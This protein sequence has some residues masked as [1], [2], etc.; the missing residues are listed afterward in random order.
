MKCFEKKKKKTFFIP[1]EMNP[2]CGNSLFT[3]N[4]NIFFEQ[5]KSRKS[6]SKEKNE[7]EIIQIFQWI[8]GR[9][10]GGGG[11]WD[12]GCIIW[13]KRVGVG[14]WAIP[15]TPTSLTATINLGDT[16]VLGVS[17]RGLWIEARI[18]RR[19]IYWFL[20]RLQWILC[21]Y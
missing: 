2:F 21:Y 5:S 10:Y 8:Q 4:G 12:E 17:R 3:E 11:Y 20:F 7:T 15:P 13:M 16:F 18:K 1:K 9:C 19:Q 14:Y 6:L